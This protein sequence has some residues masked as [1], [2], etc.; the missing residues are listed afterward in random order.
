[1]EHSLISGRTKYIRS[2]K[3]DWIIEYLVC[4]HMYVQTDVCL[5]ANYSSIATRDG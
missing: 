5:F 2:S 4:M 3:N 1:M